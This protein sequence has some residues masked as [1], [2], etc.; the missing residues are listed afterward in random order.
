MDPDISSPVSW[1]PRTN[2]HRPERPGTRRVYSSRSDRR[3]ADGHHY[4]R[5]SRRCCTWRARHDPGPSDRAD[6]RHRRRAARRARGGRPA[7]AAAGARPRHRR[8]VA[9]APGAAHRSVADDRGPGRADARATGGRPRAGARNARGVPR[10]RQRHRADAH[11][12]RPQADP[13]VP[14]GRAGDRRVPAD[15]ARGA[16]A[17]RR[18]PRAAVAQGRRQPRQA[19]PSRRHRRRHVGHRCRLPAGRSGRALRRAGQE[20]RRRRHLAGEQLPGLPR[21]RPEPLLQLLVR[22]ARRLAALLQPTVRALPVLPQLRRRVRDP[23][24]HPVQHRGLVGR[25][26]RRVGHVDRVHGRARRRRGR[27]SRPTR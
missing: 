14:G 23:P 27:R 26:R 25:V 8:P 2:L 1:V 21:R 6:H 24:Q 16:G 15:D 11:R 19:V 5:G 9:A 4:V 12:D 18:P 17:D 20:R 10:R 13:P 22:P 3:N 7:G